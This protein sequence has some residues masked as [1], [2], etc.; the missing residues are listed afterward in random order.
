MRFLITGSAGFIGFHLCQRLLKDGHEV[1]GFDAMTPY[2]D[3]ALK[4]ARLALLRKSNAFHQITAR[5]E[6]RDALLA[7]ARMAAPDAVVH[8]AAQPG[9]RYSLEN[10]RAYIDSNL[11]GSWSVLDVAR[12][13]RPKHLMLASTSSIYGANPKV[14][15]AETDRTDAPLSLYAAT[16]KSM[17]AMAHAYAHLYQLPTT[18]FRFFTVYGP[19]GRPD[20]AIF[21]F[22]RAILEGT[23]IDVYGGG[24]MRRDF[25]FIG[26]LVEAILRLVPLAPGSSDETPVPYRVVNI[27]GGQPESLPDFIAAIEKATGRTAIQHLLPMQPGDVPQTHA[28]PDLLVELTGYKP[29]TPLST[30]VAQF[31]DWYRRH[32]G[33]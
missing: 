17:E 26:D 30:G 12:E 32:Y 11:V 3:P 31:V 6:D 2:Y 1:T 27:G 5:L 16:K 9:V 25:T 18:A 20:M 14:P 13:V 7:A 4:Q 23:P 10:P 8:L 21:K 15:F 29:D 33:V 24:K 22:T 28:A 19:W